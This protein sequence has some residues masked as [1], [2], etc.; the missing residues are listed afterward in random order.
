MVGLKSEAT[1]SGGLRLTMVR[2][3]EEGIRRR[4][5]WHRRPPLSAEPSTP[6]PVSRAARAVLAA[7]IA[8]YLGIYLLWSIRN[9]STFATY[10]FDLGIHD[11]AAWLLSRGH[12]PFV[13]VSGADYFGDHLYWIMVFVVPFYWIVPSAYTLLVLQTLAIGLAAIPA[14]VLARHKLRNEWLACGAAWAFLLNPYI[15]WLNRV[16]F[17]PDAFAVPLV[18]LTF[19]FA[20][21]KRW[22]WFFVMAALLMLVK[23]DVPLL[24]LGLGVWI[25]FVLDRRVGVKTTALAALWL[26]TNLRILLPAL[27]ETGSLNGYISA[28]VSRIPFGGM[29]GF[30]KALVTR[31][32]RVVAHLFSEGRPLYYVQVFTPAAFLPWLSPSTLAA[33]IL[34]LLANG[35]STWGAQH[36]LQAQYGALV[37]PGLTVAAIL[38]I[39]HGSSW[40]RRGMVAVM[41]VGALLGLWLWGPLPGTHEPASWPSRS[42]SYLEAADEAMALIPPDAAI[43]VDWRFTPHLDHRVTVYEFPNPWLLTNWGD[44]RSEGQ[45]LP[46]RAGQV[47]YV[48]FCRDTDVESDVQAVFDRL[49]ASGEFKVVFD[50]ESIVLLERE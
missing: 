3:S 2:T 28:H 26:F 48:L 4:V 35:L 23:E 37:V 20:I 50:R 31:P 41:I 1:P 13:T 29:G 6:I 17:H 27:S 40:V 34:P 7:G 32:W 43:S 9:Q 46:A 44:R 19:Y 18:F 25:T 14:F 10:G 12:D 5:S 33:V 8:I 22:A 24:V 45:S 39:A 47:E 38:A 15:Q 49:A 36:S 11:Q 30:L 42:S 21:R 16:Q